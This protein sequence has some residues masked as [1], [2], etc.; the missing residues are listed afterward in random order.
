MI[1]V[2]D[3]HFE[4]FDPWNWLGSILGSVFKPMSKEGRGGFGQV[5]RSWEHNAQHAQSAKQI[6]LPANEGHFYSLE[7]A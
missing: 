4:I 3:L 1:D 2:G 7:M 5:A 6:S